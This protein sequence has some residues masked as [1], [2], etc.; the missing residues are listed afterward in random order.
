MKSYYSLISACVLAVFLLAGCCDDPLC[1]P[2]PA[3]P[4]CACPLIYAPVCG[5]DGVTY[6]NSCVAACHNIFITSPGE[7]PCTPG[8]VD[9]E[10]AC[11]ENWDPVCGC[12]GVTYSNACFA[13]CAGITDFVEGDCE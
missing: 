6:G 5:C 11:P 13:E 2:K 10:C 8:E 9:P 3:A 4:G 7:C 1:N 12:D